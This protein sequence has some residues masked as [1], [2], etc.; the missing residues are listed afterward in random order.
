V[1]RKRAKGPDAR[2]DDP[3][4]MHFS[5]ATAIFYILMTTTTTTTATTTCWQIRL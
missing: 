4:P 1:E 5:T 3:H 2:A